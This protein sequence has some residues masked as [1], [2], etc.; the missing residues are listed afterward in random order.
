MRYDIECQAE[1][2][3]LLRG[4]LHSVGRGPTRAIVMTHGFSG[5]KEQIDHYAAHFGRAGFSVFVYDHRGL[6]ASEGVTRLGN[7]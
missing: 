1:D 5:I 2:G 4:Y 6:G 7:I 3:I